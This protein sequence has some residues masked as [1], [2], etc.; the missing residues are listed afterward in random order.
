VWHFALRKGAVENGPNRVYALEVTEKKKSGSL[1]RVLALGALVVAILAGAALFGFRAWLPGYV[2]D[3]VQKAALERGVTLSE[4]ALDFERE[5]FSV[6]QVTLSGCRFTTDQPLN[7]SGTIQHIEIGLRENMPE[8]VFMSGADVTVTG[9]PDWQEWKGQLGHD[10]NLAVTGQANRVAWITDPGRPP[11]IAISDLQRLSPAE[12]WTGKLVLAEILEGNVRLGDKARVELRVRSLPANTLVAEVDPV[13]SV[14]QVQLELANV[15]FMLFSGILFANVPSELA[16]TTASGSLALEIP[17][18]L[19]TAEPKGQFDLTL[20]G[21]NFPVPREVAGLVYDTSPRLSGTLTSNRA[22]TKFT[23]NK[24]QFETGA[25]R[26]KG[27]A[28]IER[29]GVRTRWLSTM[30]GPLSCDAILAAAARVHLSGTPIGNELSK[31][32]ANIS[33]KAIKGTVNVIV[34]L[35]AD[36]QDLANAKV[37]K[38]V[39]L[40]CGLKPLPVPSLKDLPEILLKDLPQLKDLPMG[41]VDANSDLT[42]PGLRLPDLRRLPNRL[43][44]LQLPEMRLPGSKKSPPGEPAG[45]E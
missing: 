30:Q 35:D 39:G 16:T 17:Y 45:A 38:S 44:K 37:I 21:L 29:D 27:K 2:M 26:M 41:G 8:K 12:D 3:Q 19:N 9:T 32:A 34:A 22:Y 28:T 6:S 36:S 4:C 13:R 14:G 11:A 23:A 18:G 40:G 15:P 43:P 7:A 20:A 25:L 24:L 1:L 31:A 10:P 42:K 5:G 33:R